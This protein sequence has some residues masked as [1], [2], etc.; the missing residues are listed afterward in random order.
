MKESIEDILNNSKLL[1]METPTDHK[2]ELDVDNMLVDGKSDRQDDSADNEEEG[3]DDNDN[4][5]NDKEEEDDDNNDNNDPPPPPPPQQQVIISF[6]HTI[7]AQ[8]DI[9]TGT[10]S[11]H[12]LQV[13][14]KKYL[15]ISPFVLCST[16]YTSLQGTCA[17]TCVTN[18]K[19]HLSPNGEMANSTAKKPSALNS[20]PNAC[21]I[22]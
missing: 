9:Y 22:R 2:K 11:K 20:D 13:S 16:N 10:S 7:H 17:P 18:C 21:V 8:S 5:D 14:H 4:D 19:S 12:I 3:E 15:V 6:P 1:H